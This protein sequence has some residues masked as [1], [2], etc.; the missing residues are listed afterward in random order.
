[1]DRD[2]SWRSVSVRSSK[3]PQHI[4]SITDGFDDVCPPVVAILSRQEF[5]L[6]F[7]IHSKTASP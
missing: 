5:V 2:I 6:E 4:E 7:H 3:C 1:M